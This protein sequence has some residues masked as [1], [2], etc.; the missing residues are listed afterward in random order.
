MA[1][2][3]SNTRTLIMTEL[4]TNRTEFYWLSYYSR[5]IY[6]FGFSIGY[7]D[8]DFNCFFQDHHVHLSFYI[9]Y[10]YKPFHTT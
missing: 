8:F 4:L 7:K 1:G 3:A 5:V 9:T 6:G 2:D 10:R